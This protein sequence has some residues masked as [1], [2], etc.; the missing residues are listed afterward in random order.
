MLA[1]R[2]CNIQHPTL[3][4]LIFFL[5]VR[6][7]VG[8]VVCAWVWVWACVCALWFVYF[9]FL[10]LFPFHPWISLFSVF[11]CYSICIIITHFC[12]VL[13]IMEYDLRVS[14]FSFASTL[15]STAAAAAS[16]IHCCRSFVIQLLQTYTAYTVAPFRFLRSSAQS[17]SHHRNI[18]VC[19]SEYSDV[20]TVKDWQTTLPPP[21]TMTT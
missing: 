20:S 2:R 5:F 12:F 10:L 14:R 11:D 21:P 17:P 19:L 15:S 6:S 8:C 9:I 16:S 1:N 3:L 18:E 13:K 4:L 7:S